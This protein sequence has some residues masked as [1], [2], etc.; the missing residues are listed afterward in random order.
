TRATAPRFQPA[1]DSR[2]ERDQHDEHD[3]R[4]DVLVDTRNVAAQEIADEQHPPD[5]PQSTDDVVERVLAVSHLRHTRHDGDE[6]TD[7]RHET[8]NDDGFSPVTLVELVGAVEMLLVEQQ[9]ILTR[10]EARP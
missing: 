5:P 1:D 4:L 10:E 2:K 7:D 8:S 3:D 9:R 6:R